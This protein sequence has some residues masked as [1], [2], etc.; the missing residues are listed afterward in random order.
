MR[1]TPYLVA[2]L[3]PLFAAHIA[4]SPLAESPSAF[5]RAHASS[6]VRFERWGDAA[7]ARAKAEQKPVYVV[8]GAFTQELARAMREQSFAREENAALLNESFICV[9]VDRDERPDLAAFLQAYVN[10]VKQM[11]GWP[12]NVWL[13]PELKPF[14]GASYLPPS[15]E[16]GKEGFPNAVRRVVSAWQSDPEAQRAKADE[17]LATLS[18][19]A[20]AAPPAID[21]SALTALVD[22]A[23]AGWM[24]VYDAATGG[25]GDPPRRLEPELFRFLLAT[26]DTAAR[27]AARVTLNAILASPVRDPLDGGFFRS[28][29]DPAWQQPTFQKTLADQA[30]MALALRAVSDPRFHAAAGAALGHAVTLGTPGQGLAGADDGTPESIL[31][32]FFW[33]LEQLRSALGGDAT[34]DV[35]AALGC[36][37]AG[38][39]PA[40]A[41]I[42]VDTAGKNLPRLSGEPV[43]GAVLTRLRE[44]RAE[45]PAPLRDGPAP[46]GA[47]GLV[48]QALAQSDDPASRAA[49]D[50]LVGFIRTR[51]LTG[52]GWLRA[53]PSSEVP[54]PARDHALVSGGL[55]ALADA[56]KGAAAR[57]LALDLVAKA[58]ALYWDSVSGRYLASDAAPLTGVWLRVAAPAPEASEAFGAETAML[59]L[60]S[61]HAIGTP[62]HRARLAATIAADLRDSPTLARGDQVLALQAYLAANQQ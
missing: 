58:D 35:I 62:E 42:G 1:R 24:A 43:A 57:T 17:A 19:F 14:D 38:N 26:D 32:S 61:T 52:E 27:E 60:L 13:T 54:A 46:A 51:L 28:A 29:S 34:A 44:A 10:V 23:R 48:L 8:V 21:G 40:D 59:H 12:L 41:Y 37:E 47:L 45:R 11:Q 30:R 9:V 5:E 31:P 36:T 6:P 3:L 25:F 18:A 15:D 33:T 39:V 2:A 22:E 49:A 55:L 4:A 16:W 7:F 50:E 53:T 56:T 20:P